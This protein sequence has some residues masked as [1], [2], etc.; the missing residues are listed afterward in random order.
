MSDFDAHL[1]VAEIAVGLAGFTGIVVV[2][3]RDP[4]HWVPADGYRFVILLTASF[5]ALFLALLPVGFGMLGASPDLALTASG[6]SMAAYTV[7]SCLA[8]APLA[9]RILRES[10]ALFS[11]WVFLFVAT[12]SLVN[13]A[14]QVCNSVV[15]AEPNP[16]VYF[17]GLLWY[18]L[19]ACVQFARLLFV[20]PG[21]GTISRPLSSA[22]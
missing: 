16:G 4:A 13:A 9:W 3:G 12:G 2:F 15:A 18:L 20:R 19:F 10:R 11:V 22:R 6:L 21:A 1:A 7:G 14:A 8:L 5:G 17:L